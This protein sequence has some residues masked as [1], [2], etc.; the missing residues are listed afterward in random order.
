M[1]SRSSSKPG[2]VPSSRG[3]NVAAQPTCM[4]AVGVS[5]SRNDAS[6]AESRVADIAATPPQVCFE[7][8]FARTVAKSDVLPKPT[9]KGLLS[10]LA[11]TAGQRLRACSDPDRLR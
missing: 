4:C 2:V 10:G 9:G 8:G 6:S 5:T 1:W 11:S 7:Y 3:A